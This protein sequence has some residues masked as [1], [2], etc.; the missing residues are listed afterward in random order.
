METTDETII[1]QSKKKL[2]LIILGSLALV[3]AGAWMLSLDADEIRSGRSFNFFFRSP[4]VVYGFGGAGV[5]CFGL[6]AAYAFKKMFD[7]RPGLVLNSSGFID[8]ASGIAAG[9]IPWTEVTGA[10]VYEIQGQKMLTVGLRD[11][12]KYI[13][14][15]SA[16]KRALNKAN[17]GMVGSP[18][19]ISSVALKINFAELV[20]LFERYH[21]KYGGP[22]AGGER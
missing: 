12:Q 22:P 20:S 13:D 6:S 5:I 10:G 1:E 16:L 4:A 9:F 15:G 18:V 7:K 14:R 11:P 17:S 2:V 21:R 19:S 8:N 3:A